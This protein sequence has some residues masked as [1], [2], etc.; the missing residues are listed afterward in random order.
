MSRQAALHSTTLHIADLYR[1]TTLHTTSCFSVAQDVTIHGR[2]SPGEPVSFS[3]HSH[4]YMPDEKVSIYYHRI[5]AHS[6]IGKFS[7]Y[8]EIQTT[9]TRRGDKKVVCSGVASVA[10]VYRYIA[11][12]GCAVVQS[13]RVGW[14]K[15]PHVISSIASHL[16]CI[17][18]IHI[19]LYTIFSPHTVSSAFAAV[20]CARI[21]SS[22]FSTI[23]SP[24]LFCCLTY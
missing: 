21:Y 9:A 7:G 23:F 11:Q 13:T 6:V 22:I 16:T 20:Y 19:Y 2:K 12:R 24:S 5:K 18:C 4:T 15:N 10:A 1:A 14:E 8:I 3:T 17:L